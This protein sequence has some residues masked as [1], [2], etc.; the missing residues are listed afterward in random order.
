MSLFAFA[1]GFFSLGAPT[2]VVTPPTPATVNS[3][4]SDAS[5][6][7]ATT[8]PVSVS[9]DTYYIAIV[10]KNGDTATLTT[11]AGYSVA[12]D[13]NSSVSPGRLVLYT[14]DS[15]GES[16]GTVTVTASAA[17]SAAWAFIKVTGARRDLQT[18]QASFATAFTA[19]AVTAVDSVSQVWHFVASAQWPRTFLV[20]S[21]Y[22]E[23]ADVTATAGPALVVAD[24]AAT[25]GIV[26]TANYTPQDGG[27]TTGDDYM[28]ISIALAG[29]GTADPSFTSGTFT[30]TQTPTVNIPYANAGDTLYLA[31]NVKDNTV[32]SLTTP[33]GWTL[34]ES[35]AGTFG[36][37]S[38]YPLLA[39]YR[40]DI[41]VYQA[42][43]TQGLSFSAVITDGAYL[44]YRATGAYRASAK[45][46][47]SAAAW[48]AP[49]VT[50]AA[51]N[52]TLLQFVG[53]GHY[54]R[55][56][57]P[58]AGFTEIVDTT[59][60]AGPS[61]AL[62]VKTVASGV[63]GTA[64]WTPDSAEDYQSISV[65]LDPVGGTGGGGGGGGTTSAMFI[66][67]HQHG[68][69]Q[70]NADRFASGTFQSSV[71]TMEP[72]NYGPIRRHDVEQFE[73]EN[74]VGFS[75]WWVGSSRTPGVSGA[76]VYNWAVLDAW[77]DKVY[78]QRGHP[79]LLCFF[80]MP[81]H[82]DRLQIP[83]T[84]YPSLIGDSGP[85]NFTA[86]T[87][88]V[89]DTIN[90]IE[91]RHGAAALIGIEAWN[92]ALGEENAPPA[93]VPGVRSKF[94]NATNYTAYSGTDAIQTLF[95]DITA[96]VYSGVQASSL[97]NLPVLYGAQAYLSS[98]NLDRLFGAKTS[99]G[100]FAYNYATGLS[101]H[102]YGV[103]AGTGGVPDAVS[104]AALGATLRSRLAAI[105][106]SSW[107]LWAT[108]V[109]LHADWN[110]DNTA[111]WN[112]LTYQQKADALYAWAKEYSDDGWKALF[113]YSSDED[114][115]QAPGYASGYIGSPGVSS[116]VIRDSLSRIYKDFQSTNVPDPVPND[117]APLG[118]SAASW[119]LTFEDHFDTPGL[120]LSKWSDRIWYGERPHINAGANVGYPDGTIN[121]DVNVG[122][123]SLLRIW[124]ML[125]QSG[126]FFDR[127]IHTD[128]TG[129]ATGYVDASGNFVNT[130]SKFVQ[131]YGYFEMR[132]KLP[133][134]RGCW[135]AFWLFGHFDRQN[136][137]PVRPEADIMEAYAGGYDSTNGASP[138]WANASLQPITWAPAFHLDVGVELDRVDFG[139]YMTTPGG[140]LSDA[141]NVYGMRWTAGGVFT[142]YFNGAQVGTY[143]ITMGDR[144]DTYPLAVYLDLWF[145]SASGW[146]STAETPIGQSNSY[147]IDY[148]RVWR[149]R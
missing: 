56:V 14:K 19:P 26:P 24:K 73:D 64:N 58:P 44:A 53:S 60:V 96:A 46:T 21:G 79:I 102:P 103:H 92:E 68:S 75:R 127:T 146:A 67:S 83:S 120:N 85:A 145:G 38:T 136:T 98:G 5:S 13:V 1:D 134:G 81:R 86:F 122:G 22:T 141:F 29:S 78:V 104:V 143:T 52:S 17:V 18:A 100:V 59:N 99:S 118:Q 132:A 129:G 25:A 32:P 35:Q 61:I 124:P 28:A 37:D 94:L 93:Q 110:S 147:E 106:K 15:T 80:G 55:T 84:G 72:F 20:P 91:Q 139:P 50:A 45:N 121:Y 97:P 2:S 117:T 47:G 133:R 101:V 65:V 27:V 12:A 113:T 131:K 125:N 30:A 66:G 49:S 76:N 3:G 23:R 36:G 123:N 89:T 138:G 149:A 71:N 7:I 116:Q 148:V 88:F 42:A 108:E 31:V 82:A 57:T 109:G 87:E 62:G 77:T 144:F 74:D 112:S 6:S 41:S 34:V 69:K 70:S 33:S 126:K 10:Y 142:W 51:A 111:W 16:A 63:S 135:P 90:H 128:A 54:P 140:I 119:A 39:V 105:G 9:G 43:T 95:A 48:V 8:R 114:H 130:G 4:Y 107:Q 137:L 11:P 115:E 40:K